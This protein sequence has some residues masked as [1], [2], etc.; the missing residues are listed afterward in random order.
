MYKIL[1]VDDE[2]IVLNAI[3]D[4]IDW[5]S[6]GFDCPVCANNGEHA[7]QI[8][9]SG[10]SPNVVIT[11]ICMPRMNGLE[12]AENLDE[13]LPDCTVIVLSGHDDFSYVQKA[14]KLK[15]FDYILKPITPNELIAVLQNVRGYLYEN[16]TEYEKNI[17]HAYH[18]NRVLTSN[19]CRLDVVQS[20]FNPYKITELDN[21]VVINIDISSNHS[22][23]IHEIDV[24]RYSLF[25][26][27]SE[28]SAQSN[29][30]A[31]TQMN[32]GTTS[33]ILC[34][35]ADSN[36]KSLVS[37]LLEKIIS[38][39][40]ITVKLPISS[41]VSSLI[42]TALALPDAY[43]QAKD[44]LEYKFLNEHYS[45]LFCDEIDTS[46]SNNSLSLDYHK[47]IILAIENSNKSQAQALTNDL[48]EEMKSSLFTYNHCISY[49][50]MLLLS[51]SSK[52]ETILGTTSSR[53]FD[54]ISSTTS[55]DINTLKSA[56]LSII[57]NCFDMLECS[58][59][60][61]TDM[62]INKSKQYIE[63]NYKMPKLSLKDISDHIELSPSHFSALFKSKTN[64]TF[65][66]YLTKIRIEKAKQLLSYTDKKSYEIAYEVGFSD[67]H[68]FSLVFK[69]YTQKSPK[70]FRENAYEE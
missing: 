39:F 59:N 27:V 49:I 24:N 41:S 32:N 15:I 8:I 57:D 2:K 70:E 43:K 67:P 48:F 51:M 12:L 17:L 18:M 19:S 20:L 13:V 10:F 34:I 62:Q 54:Y 6:F 35:S 31:C 38:I 42:D 9:N 16:D 30:I 65:I 4:I 50:N 45:I 55:Q 44:G 28:V 29:N 66:E 1:L 52:I 40:K 64:M 68:Y 26:V 22:N 7:L 46:I 21:F 33:L 25:N 11:D 63:D 23:T 69:K 58:K 5:N 61:N 14:L 53:D 56:V 3:S 47:K 37:R 60:T 36:Y